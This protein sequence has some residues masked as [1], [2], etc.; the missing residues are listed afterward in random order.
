MFESVREGS[1]ID[2]L[3]IVDVGLGKDLELPRKFREHP[4]LTE[5][6]PPLREPRAG[7]AE[8]ALEH[9]RHPAQ[10]REFFGLLRGERGAVAEPFGEIAGVIP[11]LPHEF[12][13]LHHALFPALERGEADAREF[14]RAADIVEK[15]LL[16]RRGVRRREFAKRHVE[17]V[18]AVRKVVIVPRIYALHV[19]HI[20]RSEVVHPLAVHERD[21]ETRY[22]PRGKRRHHGH[23]RYAE[24]ALALV[25]FRRAFAGG[26]F[27]LFGELVRIRRE[28]RL[29][30][31]DVA[32]FF[33][34][35]IAS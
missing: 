14:R 30:L 10:F 35:H 25:L 29:F 5:E 27:V 8:R 24:G 33:P 16:C 3:R 17:V 23:R 9:S 26:S 7:V 28:R 21:G 11:R 15:L 31:F 22:A 19:P 32:A 34:V 1:V 13:R 12:A 18:R 6:E 20:L 2:H 4:A